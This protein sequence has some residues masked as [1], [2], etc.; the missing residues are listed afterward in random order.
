MGKEIKKLRSTELQRNNKDCCVLKN[1]LFL[2][3]FTF[4]I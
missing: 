3:D 4:K 2:V 1:E